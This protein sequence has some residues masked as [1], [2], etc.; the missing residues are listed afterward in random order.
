MCLTSLRSML[1][2]VPAEGSDFKMLSCHKQNVSILEIGLHVVQIFLTTNIIDQITSVYD[3]SKI[4]T[5]LQMN[6]S[7]IKFG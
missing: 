1:S 3:I 4:N 2:T 6:R 5:F 7:V